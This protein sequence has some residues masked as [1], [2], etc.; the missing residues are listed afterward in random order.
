MNNNI[1]KLLE[2]FEYFN[3]NI[4]QLEEDIKILENILR[5]HRNNYN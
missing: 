4:K 1:E 3:F 2:L 5:S